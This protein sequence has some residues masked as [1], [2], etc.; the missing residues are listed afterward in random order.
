[1]IWGEE[2]SLLEQADTLRRQFFQIEHRGESGPT[3][4]PPV[5]ILATDRELII[6]VALPGV[7]AEQLDVIIGDSG[8]VVV[9][10]RHAMP[11]CTKAAAIYRLEIP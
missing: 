9:R 5:D 1:L 4:A 2:L 6:V 3:W 10:G 7:A 8:V 11:A